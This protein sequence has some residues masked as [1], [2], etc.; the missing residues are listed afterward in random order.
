V[1]RRRHLVWNFDGLQALLW[2]SAVTSAANGASANDSDDATMRAGL[3][4][5]LQLPD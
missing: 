4:I 2:R 5:R 1:E 3:T